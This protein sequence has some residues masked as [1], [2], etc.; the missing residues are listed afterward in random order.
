M[1]SKILAHMNMFLAE[2]KQTS[3]ACISKQVYAAILKSSKNKD[4]F[5]NCQTYSCQILEI[6]LAWFL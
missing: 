6:S 2:N 5:Q 4:P 3:L 1:F